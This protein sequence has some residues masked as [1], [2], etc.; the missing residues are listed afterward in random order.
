M[1]VKDIGLAVVMIISSMVL[2]Y[3]WLT[4][5]GDSDPVIIVSAML[6]VGSLAIMIILLDVRL[7]NLEEAL[8]TKERSIRINIKGV[9]D[10]L[11]KKIDELSKS[12]SNTIGEFSKRMYR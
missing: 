11:E 6:L 9:E 1:E 8:N 10:N 4:R 5:L 7:R 3:K 12:T 2:T